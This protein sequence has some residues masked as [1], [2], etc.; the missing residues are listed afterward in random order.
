MRLLYDNDVKGRYASALYTQEAGA[1][2][3]SHTS[4]LQAHLET[5]G[6]A[7]W[8]GQGAGLVAIC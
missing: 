1:S 2:Q 6:S 4:T 7:V 5:D 3:R 8:L